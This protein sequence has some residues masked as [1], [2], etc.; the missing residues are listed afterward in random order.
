MK[1]FLAN[2]IN[3]INRKKLEDYQANEN[4]YHRNKNIAVL[5]FNK[6]IAVIIAEMLIKIRKAAGLLEELL[7]EIV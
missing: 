5:N 3:L 4:T 1:K 6:K 7:Q 2:V